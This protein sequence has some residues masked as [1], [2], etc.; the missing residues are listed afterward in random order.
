VDAHLPKTLLLQANAAISGAGAFGWSCGASQTTGQP[1]RYPRSIAWFNRAIWQAHP[2][3]ITNGEIPLWNP[4]CAGLLGEPMLADGN[5]PRLS[6]SQVTLVLVPDS[7]YHPRRRTV[8]SM[9]LSRWFL[10]L[11]LPVRK[12]GYTFYRGFA[13]IVSCFPVTLWH[14]VSSAI[15]PLNTPPAAHT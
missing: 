7:F 15:S 10:L 4:Q 14:M 5:S 3:I 9:I 11:Y 6:H 1:A 8:I 12:A 13:G 2:E